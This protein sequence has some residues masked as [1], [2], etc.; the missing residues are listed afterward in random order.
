ML[1]IFVGFCGAAMIAAYLKGLITRKQNSCHY[2]HTNTEQAYCKVIQ[3]TD[4]IGIAE[5]K[6]CKK[7]GSTFTI[8]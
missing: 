5:K 1:T 6:A 3:K 2:F 8:F 7:T 4:K